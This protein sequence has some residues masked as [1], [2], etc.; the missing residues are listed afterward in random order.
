MERKEYLFLL[1][2]LFDFM[3]PLYAQ[4]TITHGN[5]KT[6][7]TQE[8]TKRKTN[9]KPDNSQVSTT[10][11]TPRPKEEVIKELLDNM[12]YIKEGSFYMGATPTQEKD[13]DANERPLHLVVLSSFYMGKYE[14]TQEEWQVVMGENPSQEKNLRCPVEN[15]SWNDCMKFIKKLN[16]ITGRN[17]CLPTE[18]QWEY[19]ARAGH[20][21]KFSGSSDIQKVAWYKW[22]SK[23]IH[24]VGQKEPNNFGLYDMSGNVGEWCLDWYAPY[25][26][27]RQ[28]DPTI[29]EGSHKISR[30]GSIHCDA[31]GCRVSVRYGEK[32]D[33]RYYNIGLRLVENTHGSINLSCSNV[34]SANVWL[35]GVYKGKTP[36]FLSN[37]VAGR[38][39][40]E[41]KADDNL[42]YN[43]EIDIIAGENKT[44]QAELR[45]APKQPITSTPQTDNIRVRGHLFDKRGDM[46]GATVYLLENGKRTGYGTV[47]DFDGNFTLYVPVSGKH[48]LSISYVKY[49]T[50]TID[51][52]KENNPKLEIQ[53][54]K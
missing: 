47:S 38:H 25:G 53:M 10:T 42:I 37:I 13:G 31:T 23:K 34:E 20:E 7:S 36:T 11:E 24:P 6:Q 28:V 5:N 22:N 46:I 17:F 3:L 49:K 21:Y 45:E 4:H 35:D 15:V 33:E 39:V 29:K 54:K 50:R 32:I 16:V 1:A 2:F 44:L 8:P 26:K 9:R 27:E 18:A 12:T 30:G 43:E 51:I 48:S 19:A 41:M 52:D 14:V 40:I